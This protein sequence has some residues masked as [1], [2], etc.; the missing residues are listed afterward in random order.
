MVALVRNEQCFARRAGR[1]YERAIVLR[2]NKATARVQYADKEVRT[3]PFA[4]MWK[5]KKKKKSPHKSQF[6]KPTSD[7]Y[8]PRAAKRCVAH[9]RRL[10]DVQSVCYG[11]GFKKGDYYRMLTDDNVRSNILCIFND[12]VHQWVEHGAHPTAP[13]HAGGGNACARPWQHLGHAIGMPTG[14]FAS[15]SD[16]H[17]VSFAGEP[18]APH[19]A[20]AIIDEATLRIVRT[21]AQHSEKDTVYFSVDTPDSHKIGLA[22]F[23]DL[24][25][26]DVVDYIS[27][28]I[29][30]IPRQVRLARLAM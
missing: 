28:K 20:K 10:V 5:Q 17:I 30:D 4:H 19:T 1:V 25:G 7:K 2:V 9:M 15:L 11:H 22:I 6:F 18:P 13:Q 8:T 12:N 16:V 21:L 14:P 3:V 26:D 24:V 29:Y 23:R 27:A